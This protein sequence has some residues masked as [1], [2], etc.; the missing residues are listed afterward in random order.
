MKALGLDPRRL[1]QE[2]ISAAEGERFAGI[3]TEFTNQMKELGPSP[4]RQAAERSA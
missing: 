3:V 1:R 4:I 2:W